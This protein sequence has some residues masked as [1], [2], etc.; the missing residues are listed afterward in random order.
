MLLQ[1]AA[2]IK[3]HDKNVR[4][5]GYDAQQECLVTGSFDRKIQVYKQL[6]EPPICA[7]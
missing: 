4:A 2:T 1:V 7:E 3:A 5:L 6:E